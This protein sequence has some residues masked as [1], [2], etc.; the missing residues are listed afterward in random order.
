MKFQAVGLTDPG[1]VRK[2]NEDNYWVDQENGLLIVAD[3]MGGHAAGE[4]ASQMAVDVIREQVTNGLRTGHI[5]S[6][7]ELPMH[8]SDRAH[9]LYSTVRMANEVVYA[10]AQEKAER[11][12]MGTTVVAVLLGKKNFAVAHVGDS[13]LY[14]FRDGKLRQVTQDHSLVAEQVAKGLLTPE[15]AEQS[16]MKNVLTRALGVGPDV[17]VDI[18]E[19]TLNPGDI[20]LLC[21]DGLCRM[22]EDGVI[23][24]ELKNARP[25]LEMSRDLI[26]IAN[27]RGGK[28][29]VTVVMAQMER[30]GLRDQIA[31]LFGRKSTR[32]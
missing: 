2:N 13:R 16:D 32:G 29:N 12:G 3:G 31:G 11:K 8:L 5:P 9:L 6:M 10:T 7:G 28:D 14:L 21:T 18:D 30:S 26:R 24:D 25:P 20:L 22:M 23:E 15:Q 1:Q 19:K 17:Q 27:E 4:V